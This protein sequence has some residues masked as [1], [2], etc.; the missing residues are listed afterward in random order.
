MPERL[1]DV[2]RKGAKLHTFPVTV[3]PPADEEVFKQ[4]ALEAAG[5]A[6]LVPNESELDSVYTTGES[7]SE[8]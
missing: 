3:N 2:Q 8:R 1:V 6:N 4:K 5:H 7:E